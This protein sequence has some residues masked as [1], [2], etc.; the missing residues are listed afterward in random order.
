MKKNLKREEKAYGVSKVCISLVI[1]CE[2][3]FM[4]GANEAFLAVDGK[5]R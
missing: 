4:Y 2:K 3:G 5:S 1:N